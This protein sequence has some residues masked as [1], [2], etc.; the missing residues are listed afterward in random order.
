MCGHWPAIA[1]LAS[2]AGATCHWLLAVIDYCTVPGS[3]R[4]IYY[5]YIY[6]LQL[7]F[8]EHLRN[9]YCLPTARLLP[10]SSAP[11]TWRSNRVQRDFVVCDLYRGDLNCGDLL[12]SVSEV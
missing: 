9:A 10:T 6:N 1:N 12:A 2:Q 3:A 4:A 8:R 11:M 7:P 5:R